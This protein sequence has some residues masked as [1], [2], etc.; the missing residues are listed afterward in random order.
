MANPL[1]YWS[2]GAPVIQS[3]SASMSEL[4]YWH[5]GEP[6]VVFEQS[7]APTGTNMQINVGDTFRTVAEMQINIGDSWKD[8]AGVSVNV[9]DTW[10]TVF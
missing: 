8:V 6:F 9:G 10:K 1:K 4:K 2:N 7:A 5:N 3:T